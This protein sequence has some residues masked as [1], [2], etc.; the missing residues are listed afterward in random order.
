MA[1]YPNERIALPGVRV[2]A[3]TIKLV[4]MRAASLRLLAA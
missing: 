3:R 1:N 4:P 2:V